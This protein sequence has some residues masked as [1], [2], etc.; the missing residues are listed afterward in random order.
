M[1]DEVVGAHSIPSAATSYAKFKGLPLSVIMKAAGW[2]QETTFEKFYHN[3]IE[4]SGD[5]NF[6]QFILAE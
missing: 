1:D 6:G 5:V 4:N 2:T 3:A